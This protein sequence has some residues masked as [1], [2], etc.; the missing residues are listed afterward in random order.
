M[1]NFQLLVQFAPRYIAPR[2]KSS[3]ELLFLGAKV[4]S[5]NF[6]SE[7]RKV[8]EP[9]P[10]SDTRIFNDFFGKI[11]LLPIKGK[12]LLTVATVKGQN[13]AGS[14]DLQQGARP[15]A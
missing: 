9:Y 5:G 10:D 12:E 8:P 13:M 14:S 4:P 3:R 1:C 11:P 15:C 6:R 7:E 2:N